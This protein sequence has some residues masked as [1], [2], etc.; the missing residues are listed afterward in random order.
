M[1]AVERFAERLL[2]ARCYGQLFDVLLGAL[3]SD[4]LRESVHRL[5]IRAHVA[6]GNW[7]EAIRHYRAY[8]E[9][10]QAELGLEPSPQIAEL[11]PSA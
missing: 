4:P 10:L 6:E 8:R 5:L 3:R 7:S 11:V 1:H 9:R 2:D